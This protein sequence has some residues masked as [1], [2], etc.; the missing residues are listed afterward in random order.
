[1]VRSM[2][3]GCERGDADASDADDVA[4]GKRLVL[5]VDA[6][7][8]RDMDARPGRRPETPST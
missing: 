3:G 1:M 4:V 6:R 7:A 2:A 5:E 8:V